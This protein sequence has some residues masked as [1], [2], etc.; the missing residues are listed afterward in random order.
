MNS[1]FAF[2]KVQQ[3]DAKRIS[4]AFIKNNGIELVAADAAANSDNVNDVKPPSAA[5]IEKTRKRIDGVDY[6]MDERGNLFKPTDMIT[7]IGEFDAKRKEINFVSES[8]AENHRTQKAVVAEKKRLKLE[9]VVVQKQAKAESGYSDK[10]E[11]VIKNESSTPIKL[12]PKP[13]AA[14]DNDDKPPAKPRNK[15]SKT[16]PVGDVGK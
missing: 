11:D 15:S 5:I 8:L 13:K 14:K 2:Q 12:N 9:A 7:S 4:E 10:A 3:V 6:M 16:Q 1:Y